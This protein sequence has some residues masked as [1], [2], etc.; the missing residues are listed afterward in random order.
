MGGGRGGAMVLG[1]RESFSLLDATVRRPDVGR[2]CS[3]IRTSIRLPS[4]QPHHG[5]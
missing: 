2:I 4:N 3:H 5:S 1:T